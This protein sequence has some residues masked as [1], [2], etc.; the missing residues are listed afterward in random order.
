MR[1]VIAPTVAVLAL[2]GLACGDGDN[3]TT[4]PVITTG[5]VEVLLT[6]T[7]EYLDADGCQ[8]S[9]DGGDSRLL[10]PGASVLFTELSADAHSLLLDGVAANCTIQGQNQRDVNV[11]AGQTVQTTY[12]VECTPCGVEWVGPTSTTTSPLGA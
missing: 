9:I 11:V 8:V 7:G 3:G 10:E 2:V 12:A 1:R 6:M 5:S 4:E